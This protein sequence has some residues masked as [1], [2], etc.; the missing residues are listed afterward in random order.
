MHGGVSRSCSTES[1]R[2]LHQARSPRPM[3]V[4][5][6]RLTGGT[7]NNRRHGSIS[8]L[9]L[10]LDTREDLPADRRPPTSQSGS[11]SGVGRDA[12]ILVVRIILHAFRTMHDSLS[13][14]RSA[15]MLIVKGKDFLLTFFLIEYSV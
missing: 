2:V 15:L 10:P 12:F 5:A 7:G 1:S 13:H 4:G 14:R 8:L 6:D 3:H 11:V 9:W